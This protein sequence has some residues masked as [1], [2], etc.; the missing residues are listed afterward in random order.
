MTFAAARVRK[1]RKL[2]GLAEYVTLDACRH[3]GMTELGD[4][5]LAEQ[6][7]MALSGHKTPDAARLYVKRKER[8]RLRAAVKRRTFI[9]ASSSAIKVEMDG[10]GE[11]ENAASP[12]TQGRI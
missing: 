3:G 8:Q 2:A 11:S 6:G 12:T 10:S 5:E 4:A 1:A 7:V 9:E